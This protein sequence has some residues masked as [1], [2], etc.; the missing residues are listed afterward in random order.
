MPDEELGKIVANGLTKAG[1]PLNCSVINVDTR[2]IPYAY[3]LYRDNYEQHYSILDE[4]VEELNGILSFGRQGLYAHD[5]TH[6]AM[7]M[8]KAAADCLRS[9]GSIDQKAWL[10]SRKI[11]ETHVVE[12]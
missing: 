5:N 12:D 1:L 2:R 10:A 8:A 7:F 3:P 4:W 11:F 6:H 9:D